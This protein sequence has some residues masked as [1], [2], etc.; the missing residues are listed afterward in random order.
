MYKTLRFASRMCLYVY[1]D[2]ENKQWLFPQVA[3]TS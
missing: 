3:L 1:C 2:S